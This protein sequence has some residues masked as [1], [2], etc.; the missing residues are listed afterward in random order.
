MIMEKHSYGT[1]VPI[2][3]NEKSSNTCILHR[4]SRVIHRE[5]KSPRKNI[6][7][8]A[9]TL[10]ARFF[11][12]FFAV[13]AFV[14]EMNKIIIIVVDVEFAYGSHSKWVSKRVNARTPYEQ[15]M[16]LNEFQRMN[17]EI[18]ACCLR[19]L[20]FLA[21]FAIRRL[22]SLYIFCFWRRRRTLLTQPP[23][24][25]LLFLFFCF[26]VFFFVFS[27]SWQLNYIYTMHLFIL[28][29]AFFLPFHSFT[30]SMS[31]WCVC[32]VCL[33]AVHKR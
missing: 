28:C 7:R 17:Y 13:H 16:P 11:F 31:W 4:R 24:K 12:L 22:F 32:I 19:R 15:F 25:L 20:P 23:H 30:S 8:G 33:C 3:A 5:A 9:C 21:L 6:H 2:S 26:F 29:T 10:L 14:V 1:I 27:S 18:M